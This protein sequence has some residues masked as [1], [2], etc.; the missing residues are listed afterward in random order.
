MATTDDGGDT[1]DDADDADDTESDDDHH[2]YHWRPRPRNGHCPLSSVCCCS[3]AKELRRRS[4]TL[5][6]KSLDKLS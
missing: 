6:C 1:D 4:R 2:G 5:F 3:S